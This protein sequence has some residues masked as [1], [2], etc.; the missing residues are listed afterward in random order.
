MSAPSYRIPNRRDVL[1]LLVAVRFLGVAAGTTVGCSQSPAGHSLLDAG[2]AVPWEQ[3]FRLHHS[4]P[5]PVI[6]STTTNT[7]AKQTCTRN[8][9]CRPEHIKPSCRA[10]CRHDSQSPRWTSTDQQGP[11]AP[12]PSHESISGPDQCILCHANGAGVPSERCLACHA[13]RG[14]R[15]DV[16]AGKGLHASP[17]VRGLEC[18]K[19][20]GEHHGQ[21]GE[22]DTLCP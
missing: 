20:H 10:W 15:T 19:C 17:A 7:K 8:R 13:H 3:R 16:G 11:G 18:V 6:I 22:C 12:S 21:L 2:T 4:R 9:D 1:A 5:G 14:L